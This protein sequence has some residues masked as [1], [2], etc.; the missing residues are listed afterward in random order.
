LDALK[1]ALQL[2]ELLL[3]AHASPVRLCKRVSASP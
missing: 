2:G 3:G 1:Q